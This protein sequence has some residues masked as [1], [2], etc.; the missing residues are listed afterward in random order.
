MLTI[1]IYKYHLSKLSEASALTAAPRSYHGKTESFRRK[2][3]ASMR[4]KVLTRAAHTKQPGARDTREASS[5]DT[6]GEQGG[7]LSGDNSD[8]H[9]DNLAPAM[10]YKQTS[11]QPAWWQQVS[12]DSSAQRQH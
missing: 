12:T 2:L 4:R 7:D 6:G 8:N 11:S 9:S 1:H 10:C 3:R 5:G